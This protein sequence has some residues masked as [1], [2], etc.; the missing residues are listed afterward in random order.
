MLDPD[1]QIKKLPEIKELS[2][3]E[4]NGEQWRTNLV[5]QVKDNDIIFLFQKGGNGYVGAF[6]AKGWRIFDINAKK[7]VIMHG[8]KLEEKAGDNYKK[9]VIL[10]DIYE[11]DADGG[12][13]CANIIVEPIA[14][15]YDGVGN[16]GGVYRR[17]ISR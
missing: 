5:Q 9:D 12:D 4:Y 14:F 16:P 3:I 15:K 13:W 11:S 6:R 17:T 8:R 2:L 10:Y 1:I 7:E